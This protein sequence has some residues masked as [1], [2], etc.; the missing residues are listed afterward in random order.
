MHPNVKLLALS[1]TL[2]FAL[3]QPA[4]AD[5]V[6]D[7]IKLKQQRAHIPSVSIAVIQDGKV[8]KKKSYGLA[9]VEQAAKAS[10]ATLYQLASVT[11]QFTATAIML[12]VEDRKLRLD[13]TI[14]SLLPDLPTAWSG[15]T[16][17]HLLN[18]TSG[19]KSYTNVATFRQTFRKDYTHKE[20]LE[21]VVKEPLEFAPGEKWNYNNTGYFLLGMLIEKVSGKSYNAFLT[22]RIFQPLGMTQTRVNEL[23]IILPNRA[24]GYIWSGNTLQ[25]GEYLSPTQPFAAGALVSTIND[26]VKWD[27]ALSGESLLKKPVLEQMWTPSHLNSGEAVTYGFG[28]GVTT[29]NGHRLISHNGGIPGFGTDISRFVDDKLT[30]IVLTNSDNA[31]PSV[32]AQGI[33]QRYLPTL[34][35]PKPP[36]AKVAPPVL[37]SYSGYYHLNGAVRTITVQKNQLLLGGP[38]PWALVPIS[39]DTFFLDNP[40]VDPSRTLRFTFQKDPQGQ[41]TKISGTMDGKPSGDAL[42]I[43]PLAHTLTPQPDPNPARSEGILATIRTFAKGAAAT[44]TLSNITPGMRRDFGDSP[45]PELSGIQKI[46]YLATQDVAS[47]GLIC[48]GSKVAKVLYYALQ[49]EKGSSYLLVYLTEDNL[50]T[51][52]DIVTR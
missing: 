2:P 3:Y 11:K 16:V 26:M 20:I 14:T 42:R 38:E 48:H 33:A 27:A 18:H 10:P 4:H 50:M 49:S 32:L 8:I 30:V 17:R 5:A 45:V 9:N 1:A 43:G 13:D 35:A 28:W 39:Q 19:I 29:T 47:Q 21:L 31:N 23:K 25:N 22:E 46:S 34:V 44:E 40:E 7:Y 36:L 51:D 37:E 41:L 6:D 15:V 12:L 24:Q 52:E